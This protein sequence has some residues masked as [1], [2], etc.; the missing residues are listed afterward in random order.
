[1]AEELSQTLRMAK[2][3]GLRQLPRYAN[4]PHDLL[5]VRHVALSGDGEPTLASNFVE[6]IETVVHL[7]ALVEAPAFQLVLLTNST[8]LDQP[9]V[10]RGLRYL[11]QDDEIWAKLDAGTQQYLDR[12]NGAN[13]SIEKITNNILELAR[14]RPVI[15]QSL[16]PSI[17]GSVPRAYEIEQ[18][19]KRLKGLK[20][21]GAKISL[22]Q[23]YSATRP[24]ARSGC[25][26]L[27]LRILTRIAEMVRRIASLRA[28]V[29]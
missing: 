9:Q 4:L 17:D 6:A 24:M 11:T 16:F 21:K 5:Q 8:G 20:Q 23:I 26:H 12:I 29:F 2:A 28:E 27:P 7:R 18:Y 15:I 22:V 19:A 14:E 10:K 3:G 25:G 13:I 1:M